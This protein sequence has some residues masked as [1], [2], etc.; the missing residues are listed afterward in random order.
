M[1]RRAMGA[2]NRLLGNRLDAPVLEIQQLGAR[3]LVQ[4]DTWLALAGA[5]TCSGLEAW[6][7]RRLAAGTELNFSKKATA[8]FSYL[9]V[10][11]GFAVDRWFG[12]ASVDP[13]NGLGKP[14]VRGDSLVALLA[15]P[16]ESASSIVRRV[17]VEE[18]RTNSTDTRFQLLPGPQFALFD[19]SSRDAMVRSTWTLSQQLDRTGYHLDGPALKVPDSIPSEPVLPGS[20]QITGSGQPIVTM[21]DGPTV[22]GY[23][24]IAVLSELD[25]DRLAQCL[26]GTQLQFRWA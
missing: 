11:G 7:A 1:D 13:R 6:T 3:L 19:Q 18:E 5:D 9:A 21:V 14:V 20:F 16:T 2:A 12:S 17:L 8:V 22:G 25:R 15:E 10:P 4:E 23:A 26:P 24:K